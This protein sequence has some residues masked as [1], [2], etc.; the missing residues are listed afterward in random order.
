MALNGP[1]LQ[2][3]LQYLYDILIIRFQI[4]R[5]CVGPLLLRDDLQL[6]EIASLLERSKY[7]VLKRGN[8]WRRRFVIQLLK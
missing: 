2:P 1:G 4:Q 3:L 8:E 5:P 7:I 6:P